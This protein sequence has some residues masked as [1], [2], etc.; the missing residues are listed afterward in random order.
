MNI[1]II[2]PNGRF[3]YAD[4]KLNTI[5]TVFPSATDS[6]PYMQDSVTPAWVNLGD[7]LIDPAPAKLAALQ[8]GIRAETDP[9]RRAELKRKMLAFTPSGFFPQ[10]RAD[11]MQHHTGLIAFDVDAKDNAE[12]LE[13]WEELK[14]EVS[15]IPYVAYFGRSLSGTGYWGLFAVPRETAKEQHKAHFAAMQEDFSAMG[16]VIDAAPSNVASLRF[17]SFDPHAFLC[18]YPELYT[19]LHITAPAPKTTAK[20]YTSTTSRTDDGK[21]PGDAFNEAHTCADVL[22]ALGFTEKK[23]T[24]NEIHFTRPGAKTRGTD[25]VVYMDNG[26]AKIYSTSVNAPTK[27]EH[28]PF[29][30]FA[31]LE[32]R[33]DWK[34]AA[35]AL[36]TTTTI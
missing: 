33:G 1:N 26:K 35:R 21:R 3:L 22:C 9:G 8:A 13:N 16:I 27:G 30:L 6:R 20:L 10:R 4:S 14:S 25:V 2:D 7:I 36:T 12:R 18:H 34:A 28:T 24:P 15:K 11:A 17:Y 31:F 19:R 32:H 29:S 5:V 23:R